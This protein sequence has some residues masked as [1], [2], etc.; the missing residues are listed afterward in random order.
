MFTRVIHY[1]SN[2]SHLAICGKYG[3]GDVIRDL[4]QVTCKACKRYINSKRNQI[5][6]KEREHTN[7][8]KGTL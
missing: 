2:T 5:M 3:V 4:K 8:L 7:Q 1:E 6:V